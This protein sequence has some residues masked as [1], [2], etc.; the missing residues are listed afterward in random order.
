MAGQAV[1][2]TGQINNLAN[3]I[4]QPATLSQTQQGLLGQ[5]HRQVNPI[6]EIDMS[7]QDGLRAGIQDAIKRGDADRAT[8]LQKVLTQKMGDERALEVAQ[9]TAASRE[10]VADVGFDKVVFQE[11][12]KDAREIIKIAGRKEHEILKQNRTDARAEDKI[13]ANLELE[14]LRRQREIATAQ[15][16]YNNSMM[17]LEA[18]DTA[19]IAAAERKLEGEMQLIEA[20]G[21]SALDLAKANNEARAAL[22]KTKSQVKL[23]FNRINATDQIT[24]SDLENMGYLVANDPTFLQMKQDSEGFAAVYD[25]LFD[26]DK[27]ANTE[28]LKKMTVKAA[29]LLQETNANL[30]EDEQPMTE[31]QAVMQTMQAAARQMTGK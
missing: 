3:S 20:R 29:K 16:K 26:T 22:S 4:L 15:L 21:Q 13:E 1:N 12:A 28:M 27:K 31:T 6:P 17:I 8:M 19:K 23:R 5:L 30:A 2:L 11:G 9:T 25:V 18:K 7:T 14:E 24:K 10:R